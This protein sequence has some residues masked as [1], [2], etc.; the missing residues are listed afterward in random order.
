MTLYRNGHLVVDLRY[1]WGILG[2]SYKE[3]PMIIRLSFL[4]AMV[5]LS[6]CETM[7]R[8]PRL[9]AF[10]G[11][12]FVGSVAATIEANRGDRRAAPAQD[13]FCGCRT[14]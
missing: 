10:G 9:T 6:G 1:P 2:N 5:L 14:Q 13:H 7:A 4:I 8:H 11:A 12:I 3:S